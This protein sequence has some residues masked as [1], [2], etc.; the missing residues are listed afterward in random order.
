M[1]SDT[2]NSCLILCHLSLLCILNAKWS[3]GR[4]KFGFGAESWQ[5]T[6]FGEV[7]ISA[8]ARE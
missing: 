4:P 8:E 2:L 5:I 3:R 6:S 1:T 7:S